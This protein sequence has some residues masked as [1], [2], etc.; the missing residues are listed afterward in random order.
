MGYNQNGAGFRD[1]Y[2]NRKRPSD[3]DWSSFQAGI[4]YRDQTTATPYVPNY[5]GGSWAPTP[6]PVSNADGDALLAGAIG[7]LF[8]VAC[9]AVF[10]A[11]WGVVLGVLYLSHFSCRGALLLPRADRPKLAVF[12]DRRVAPAAIWTHDAI[13][14][15][16][17]RGCA[18]AGFIYG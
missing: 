13:G 11:A 17:R 15:V 6:A 4:T 12:L 3:G 16:T 7:W 5:G 8:R 2:D 9:L 10:A 1:G 18:V 14:F